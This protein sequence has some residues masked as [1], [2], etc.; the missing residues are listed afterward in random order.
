MT[1]EKL[2]M[3]IFEH[4]TMGIPYTLSHEEET[5]EAVFN[6]NIQ[7]NISISVPMTQEQFQIMLK[8]KF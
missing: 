8:F 6:S 2:R 3:M 7:N 5:N 4:E 1:P